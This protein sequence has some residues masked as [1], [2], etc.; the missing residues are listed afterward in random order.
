MELY[1]RSGQKVTKTDRACALDFAGFIVL[2]HAAIIARPRISGE[3]FSALVTAKP[4]ASIAHQ[5]ALSVDLLAQKHY[6]GIP[7]DKIRSEFSDHCNPFDKLAVEG[8]KSIRNTAAGSGAGC[9]LRA[10]SGGSA[11]GV[12]AQPVSASKVNASNG[13]A[14]RL[15]HGEFVRV[16]RRICGMCRFLQ[17]GLDFVGARGFGAFQ[18]CRCVLGVDL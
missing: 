18:F 16:F 1:R 9:G 13:I 6:F 15:R 8:F 12:C 4:Q 14:H 2:A 3:H 10:I 11:F 7:S 17:C 5:R